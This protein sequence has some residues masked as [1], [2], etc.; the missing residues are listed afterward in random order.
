EVLVKVAAAGVCHSDLHTINGTIPKPLPIVPGHEGA[1]RIEALGPGTS[2]RL[3]VGD[4]VAFTWRPRCGQCDA[5]VAGNPVL[6]R[7]GRVL[8]E[9]NGLLDGTTRL[10]RGEER[11]H[12]LMGVSCFAEQVVVAEASVVPVPDGVAPEVAA[13]AAC[14]VVTGVGAVLN[15]VTDGAGRPLAVYGA[16]GVGLAAVM[17]ARVAGAEPIVAIDVDPAKLELA[18]EL[19]ATH[20]IDAR[21]GGVAERVVALTG[22]GV[23]WLVEA[24]GRPET[25]RE[26]FACLAPGGTLVAIGLTRAGATA[27]IP[28]NE[29]VQRQKRVVGALYG[30]AN[31]RPDLAR[32][33]ALHLAGRL[34]LE[35]LLGGRRPLAEAAAAFDDL[36]SGVPGRTVLLP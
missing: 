30:L 12:H 23:P 7:F 35:R 22:G 3:R 20:V 16:G 2:D 29:L 27:E 24:V 11:I 6:C 19:G 18:R 4:R 34:P 25:M 14:A 10:H 8:A 13:I 9:T 1:G 26:A 5:C 36:R 32:I 21:D 17:G 31:P 15:G 33:F 28:I